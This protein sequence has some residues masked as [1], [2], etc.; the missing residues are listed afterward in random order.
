[1]L[2]AGGSRRIGALL[3]QLLQLAYQ[4]RSDV[5]LVSFAGA[6]ATTHVRP[7]AATP[8]N[9]RTV[10]R[11]LGNIGA[12]GGTPFADAVVHANDLLA[13]ARRAHPA[14][15]RW[16]WLISDGRSREA[17]GRPPHADVRVVIDCEWQRIALGRCRELA[18]RWEA[19]YFLMEHI[20]RR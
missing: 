16:L 14:Q 4:Q 17:A 1:M 2:G 3:L 8:P 12:G 5:A 9:S 7:T 13:R 15:Q 11:W 18:A 6:R 20:E 10:Q 19:E